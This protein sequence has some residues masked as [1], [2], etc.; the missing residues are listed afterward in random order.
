MT[1][2]LTV[3]EHSA[4]A[5]LGKETNDELVSRLRD[6]AES[7]LS[8]AI[9]FMREGSTIVGELYNRGV[10][11]RSLNVPFS[12]Q[13]LKIYQ[14]KLLPE[15]AANSGWRHQCFFLPVPDQR[16]IVDGKPFKV[17][18]PEKM[19]TSDCRLIP[20]DQMTKT[21]RETAFSKE[22]YRS[23][24]QQVIWLREQK[25][26]K[27]IATVAPSAE[28]SV[29]RRSKEIVGPFPARLTKRELLKMLSS[30]PD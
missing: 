3:L 22:G 1:K 11:V 24:E 13:L 15:I 25:E 28:W 10:D 6:L 30:L 7:F 19:D 2:T 4:P 20:Y 16:R 27:A 14:G 17:V 21:E 9:T 12:T 23:P 29:D 8:S 18:D 26:R 5:Y